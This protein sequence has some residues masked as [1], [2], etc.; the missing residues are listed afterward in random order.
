MRSSGRAAVVADT[1][2]SVICGGWRWGGG[3][4]GSGAEQEF[5]PPACGGRCRNATEG[6]RG[7]HHPP[8][9]DKPHQTASNQ[10][11]SSANT[12]PRRPSRIP[13]A[14]QLRQRDATLRPIAQHIDVAPFTIHTDLPEQNRTPPNA[15]E[16]RRTSPNI[17]E[18]HRTSPNATEHRRTPPNIASPD[19]RKH[20]ETPHI[21]TAPL[22][23]LP[24]M[25]P[26]SGGMP[27]PPNFSPL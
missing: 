6:G 5:S 23:R 19:M 27:L 21:L 11:M 16:H 20:T 3:G 17:A 25:S 1:Q 4:S 15:A 14:H 22:R 9:F 10:Y 7:Q 12:P 26:F 2:A 24:Q 13:R 8:Q 18:R